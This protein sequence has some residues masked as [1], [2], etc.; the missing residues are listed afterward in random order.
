MGDMTGCSCP[1]GRGEISA[2]C[3]SRKKKR[4]LLLARGDGIRLDGC[5]HTWHHTTK[6]KKIHTGIPARPS[7]AL[8]LPALPPLVAT[9]A[10]FDQSQRFRYEALR[11]R[12]GLGVLRIPHPSPPPPP[13]RLPPSNPQ[14]GAGATLGPTA[15]RLLVKSRFIL[16]D[17]ILCTQGASPGFR[18]ADVHLLQIRKFGLQILIGI[19]RELGAVHI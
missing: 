14:P 16:C 3:T 13:P 15:L 10:A 2:R 19:S 8:P 17:A 12:R 7:P 18:V 11:I 4:V 5:P 9:K 1:N 6:A